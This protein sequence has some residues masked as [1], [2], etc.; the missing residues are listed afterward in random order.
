[1]ILSFEIIDPLDSFKTAYF[2]IMGR[3]GVYNARIKIEN[4]KAIFEPTSCDCPHGSYW[5]QTKENMK[6]NKI[7]KHIGEALDFLEREA[8]IDER[9]NKSITENGK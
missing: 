2:K 9:K 1:M 4:G 8:W 6:N 7:C 5:G 3:N